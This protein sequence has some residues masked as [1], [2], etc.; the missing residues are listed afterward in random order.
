MNGMLVGVRSGRDEVGLPRR[1]AAGR[2]RRALAT[3]TLAASVAA[4]V[5]GCGS[6]G[7]EASNAS[8]GE[9]TG[10]VEPG[11]KTSSGSAVE[12]VATIN[13]SPI[14]KS[15]YEHWLAVEK[16]GGSGSEAGHRALAFL[17]TSSWVLGEAAARKVSVSEAQVKAHL[18]H[19]EHE[20]FPKKGELQSFLKKNH[21]T[22]ADLLARVKVE[23]L[24]AGIEKQVTKKASGSGAKT[25]LADLQSHFKA[26][27][28]AVTSCK[29][30]YVMEDCKQYKGSGE[31]GLSASP[32]GKSGSG[33]STAQ[34]E[35]GSSGSSSGSSSGEA[36]K[37]PGAFSIESPAFE[38]NGAIPST[39]TCDGKG[40]SP[41][42]SWSNVPK[43]ASE[44]FLFVIDDTESGS[45]GGIRWVVGGISPSSKGVAAG[46]L[47][48]G[49]IVGSNAEGNSTYGPICPAKGKT[50]TIELVMYALK[51]PIKL[52]PGFQ[53]TAAEQEYGSTKD[54]LGEAAVSYATYRRP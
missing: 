54:L 29:P 8:N 49:A 43:G 31:P 5:A 36:Y 24:R 21:E 2:G 4:L 23:M 18:S 33:T 39:Y 17:I 7:E 10:I 27:W 38:A 52:S 53:P 32:S 26:R 35:S 25:A 47:P 50:D 15:S 34:G 42:L 19:V 44:L 16:A 48:A 28:K 3:L 11:S 40:I 30:S 37:R 1:N 45:S 13:G 6:S 9:G 46:A 20:S 22:E 51:K 41:P 14:T 12:A